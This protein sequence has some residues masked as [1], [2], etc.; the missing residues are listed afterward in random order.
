MVLTLIV[1]T[2]LSAGVCGYHVIYGKRVLLAP[3]LQANVSAQSKQMLRCVFHCQTVFFVVSTVLLL[4][5][6]FKFFPGMYTFNLL[7]FLGLNYGVFAIWQF[8]IATITPP[9]SGHMLIIQA[10][11]FLL[12]GILVMLGPLLSINRYLNN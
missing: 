5:C 7:L 2:I 10:L 4:A 11:F 6:T 1:A 8:Y 12:I 9:N 3:L